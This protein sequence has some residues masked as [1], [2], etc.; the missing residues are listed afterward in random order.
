MA[1]Q[2]QM[3]VSPVFFSRPLGLESSQETRPHSRTR[4]TG[5]ERLVRLIG[6]KD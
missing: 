3:G 5:Q 4:T 2:V 1:W 6:P